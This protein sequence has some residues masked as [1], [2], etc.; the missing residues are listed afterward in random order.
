MDNYALKQTHL[1][2]LSE[3]YFHRNK[4]THGILSHISQNRSRRH[5]EIMKFT[6]RRCLPLCSPWKNGDITLLEQKTFLRSGQIIKTSNI[7]VNHRK[8]TADKPDG[9]QNLH[10]T[11]LHFTTS[12]EQVTSNP[13]SCR[14]RQVLTRGRM[15]MKTPFCYPEHHFRSF[16]LNLQGAE[17]LFGTF[18]EAIKERLSRIKRHDYDKNAKIGLETNHPD[19]KDH[20]HGFITYKNRIYIPPNPHLRED[21]IREHHNTIAAGHPGRYKPMNSSH[22]IIGGHVYKQIFVSTLMDVKTANE[23]EFT[24]TNLTHLYTLMR[25]PLNPGSIFQSISSDHYRNP[26]DTTQYWS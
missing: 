2:T 3:R 18:P 4:T 25:Y 5:S 20:G 11:T 13:T 12:Q 10:N 7:F 1:I 8:L 26:Q 9:L 24:E 23:L 16:H 19:W 6:T 14:G 17:Y 21:L 15:I 22:E